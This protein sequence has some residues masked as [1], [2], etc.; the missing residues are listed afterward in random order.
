MSM[1]APLIGKLQCKKMYIC[2]LCYI[3]MCVCMNIHVFAC[4]YMCI[5]LSTLLNYYTCTVSHI[6]VLISK[7]RHA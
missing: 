7:F 1:F 3:I 4:M 5:C 6:S 2:I